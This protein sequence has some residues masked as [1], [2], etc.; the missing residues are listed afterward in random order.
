MTCTGIASPPPRFCTAS[1]TSPAWVDRLEPRGEEE[2][3]MLDLAFEVQDNSRL[4]CQVTVTPE[5]DGL[6][7]TLAPE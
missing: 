3:D 6:K 4:S 2:N 1:P 5:L 7:V